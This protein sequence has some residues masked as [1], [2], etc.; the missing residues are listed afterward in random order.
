M[1]DLEFIRKHVKEWPE[2]AETVRLD[3]DGEICFIGDDGVDNDFYPDGY[4]K[5]IF[6]GACGI[7]IKY[8]RDQWSAK[9]L[10]ELDVTFGEL[11]R[12]TQLRLVNHVLDGG[13]TENYVGDIWEISG[14]HDRKLLCFCNDRK[15]RAIKVTNNA[16]QN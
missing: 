5:N 6:N 2:G 10:T 14:G 13:I 16:N 8:T 12:Y 1:K 4:D 11:D 7:G 15:Y 3:R 9:D